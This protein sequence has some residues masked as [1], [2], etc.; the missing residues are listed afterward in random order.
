MSKFGLS[1]QFHGFFVFFS[2]KRSGVSHLS[3]S[4]F[5]RKS[6][7]FLA[8]LPCICLLIHLSTKVWGIKDYGNCCKSAKVSLGVEF[9]HRDL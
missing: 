8:S 1:C 4:F 6:R 9:L 5:S 7:M 2:Q 3:E